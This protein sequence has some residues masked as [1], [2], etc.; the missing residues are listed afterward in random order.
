MAAVL[1]FGASALAA[2][3]KPEPPQPA[4]GDAAPGAPAAPRV[5]RLIRVPLPIKDRVDDDVKRSIRRA[6][7]R[8]REG[9]PPGGGRR[10]TLVLEFSPDKS[11]FGRGSDFSRALSLARFL[12]SREL[13]D[14][15]TVAYIPRTIKGH[16]VLAAMACDDIVMAPDAEIGEAGID[17]DPKAPAE[18]AVLAGY[19]QIAAQRRTIHPAVARGMLDKH[20]E[21]LRVET[22]DGAEFV[23]RRDLDALQQ[24]KAIQGQP[25]TVIPQGKLGIF[26]GREARDLGLARYLAAD[27]MSVARAL[28]LPAEAM[29]EDLL[30]EGPMHGAT[31]MVSGW[32]DSRL[33]ETRQ[34]MIERAI[35]EHDANLVCIWIDSPGGDTEAALRLAKFIAGLDPAQTLTVAYIPREARGASVLLA[36]ACDQ[37]VM[38][39]SARLGGGDDLPTDQELLDLRSALKDDILLKRKRSWS[40]PIALMDPKL[41][42]HQYT[43]VKSNLQDW[44]SP[45]ELAE[46]PDKGDWQRGPQVTLDGRAL[47]VTADQAEQ[48][49]LLRERGLVDSFDQFKS[50]YGLTSDPTM[51]EPTWVDRLIHI[52]ASPGIGAILWLVGL[53]GLY[54]ELKMPGTGVG[55]FVAIVAFVLFFWAHYLEQTASALEIVLFITGLLFVVLEVFVLPGHAIFGLG[56][57][58]MIIM[59]LVLA[60]QTFVIPHNSSQVRELRDSLLAICG[61]GV[62]FVATAMV[63]RRY[64]PESTLM[65]P[66][67]LQP[68]EGAQAAELQVRESLADFR[69]LIGQQ[70]TTVTQLTPS[71]KARFG[72]ELVNVS[73]DGEWIAAGTPVVVVEAHGSRVRVE[74][75]G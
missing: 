58:V 30:I 37:I 31:V 73:S 7:A 47:A 5:G 60:S 43:N 23:A 56:G 19:A 45:D 15:K 6:L 18:D 11:E 22:Q 50:L 12:T 57:G 62:G 65:R 61:A 20:E 51:V 74:V 28:E 21:V 70:G 44:F 64:L 72:E 4:A 63:L 2:P 24:R 1:L 55:G 13:A 53:V 68:P 33:V 16:A 8:L 75:V 27:R 39:R 46:Q 17:E 54:T 14:V 34:K 49:G 10:I 25:Q 38:Q 69:H 40:L 66:M 41:P 36:L 71:G 32:I 59:S 48:L 42:V 52:L 26:S 67:M 3:D 29:E 35:K 9:E